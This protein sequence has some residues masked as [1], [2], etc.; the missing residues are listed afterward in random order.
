MAFIHAI[1]YI[2]KINIK[3]IIIDMNWVHRLKV[4]GIPKRKTMQITKA[5]KVLS[6]WFLIYEAF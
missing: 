4:N 2:Y 6:I 1:S 3:G 5:D